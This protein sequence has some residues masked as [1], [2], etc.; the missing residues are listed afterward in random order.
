[1][2]TV[3]ARG[4]RRCFTSA[5]PAKMVW[6]GIV[7]IAHVEDYAN[8]ALDLDESLS[9]TFPLNVRGVETYARR[10]G[11]RVETRLAFALRK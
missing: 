3:S 6:V 1:M 10:T 11:E 4:Q 2:A 9:L 5:H 8:G 7:R